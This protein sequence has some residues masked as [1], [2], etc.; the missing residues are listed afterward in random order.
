MLK[1]KN[2]V[3]KGFSKKICRFE[4]ISVL[5]LSSCATRHTGKK[6]KLFVT[7][8]KL[9]IVVLAS[10]KRL[11]LTVHLLV[12]D[13]PSWHSTDRK[14]T[15]DTNSHFIPFTSEPVKAG[16]L[17]QCCPGLLSSLRLLQARLAAV[18]QLW[19]ALTLFSSCS[20]ANEI[21]LGHREI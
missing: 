21:A 18:P 19:L 6:A 10:M 9:K 20:S 17:S 12:N 7:K 16:F 8:T 14:V 1:S 4:H 15:S 5:V 2:I 3:L 13:N 11:Q